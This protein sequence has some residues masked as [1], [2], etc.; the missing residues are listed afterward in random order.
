MTAHSIGRVFLVSLMSLLRHN[1][2]NL[3]I[4]DHRPPTPDPREPSLAL[5]IAPSLLSAFPEV[6]AP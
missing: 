4:P 2:T 3:S 1:E 5:E 6:L